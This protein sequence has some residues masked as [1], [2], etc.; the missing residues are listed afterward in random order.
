MLGV[1]LQEWSSLM[2]EVFKL[3]R[4]V[5]PSFHSVEKL[6][7]AALVYIIFRIKGDELT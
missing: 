4:E 3:R 6:G 1:S 5:G 7:Q 2:V